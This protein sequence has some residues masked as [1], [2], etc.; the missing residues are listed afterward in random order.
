M[1]LPGTA[2]RRAR[3]TP[4][5]PGR[6]RSASSRRA[7]SARSQ[8]DPD[9]PGTPLRTAAASSPSRALRARLNRRPSR[10]CRPPGRRRCSRPKTRR[11][12][13]DGRSG[14]PSP[15]SRAARSRPTSRWPTFF[16]LARTQPSG[17][18]NRR[19]FRM[20][21]ALQTPTPGVVKTRTA[22]SSRAAAIDVPFGRERRPRTSSQCL[23]V[24]FQRR[25][26]EVSQT[27]TLPKR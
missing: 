18:S 17:R 5:R 4:S 9:W 24:T 15:G 3:R 7:C 27:A 20:Q 11:R 1:V 26:P 21:R 6:R 14:R 13:S 23:V 2:G 12:K 25:R 19:A 22:P 16:R 8:I 10:T